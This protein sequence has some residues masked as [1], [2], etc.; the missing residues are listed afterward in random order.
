MK[1]TLALRFFRVYFPFFPSFMS[2]LYYAMRDEKLSGNVHFQLAGIL[3]LYHAPVHPYHSGSWMNG[4]DH[5]TSSHRILLYFPEYQSRK[6]II[7]NCQ[8]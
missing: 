3:P 6:C 5:T 7:Y 8:L 4:W 2:D 1:F